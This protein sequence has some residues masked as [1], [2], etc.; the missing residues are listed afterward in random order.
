MMRLLYTAEEA[1]RSYIVSWLQSK[2]LFLKRFFKKHVDFK[3][4]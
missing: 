3:A 4:I 1:T 2:E